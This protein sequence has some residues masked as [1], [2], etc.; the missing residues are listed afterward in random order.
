MRQRWELKAVCVFPNFLFTVLIR[1]AGKCHIHLFADA[2][3][4]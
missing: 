2:G 4:A 3:G 1:L